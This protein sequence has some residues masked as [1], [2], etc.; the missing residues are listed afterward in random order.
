MNKDELIKQAEKV[1][2]E[3]KR[4]CCGIKAANN[5]RAVGQMSKVIVTGKQNG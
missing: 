1:K 2:K 3:G 5:I 4:I